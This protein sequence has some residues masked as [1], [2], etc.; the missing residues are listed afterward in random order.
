MK[1][2][3]WPWTKD[4]RDGHP[5]GSAWQPFQMASYI[6]SISVAVS[7]ELQQS[8]AAGSRQP[9]SPPTPPDPTPSLYSSTI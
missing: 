1:W 7:W 5:T 3:E 9:P 6:S 4:R 2:T 8:P